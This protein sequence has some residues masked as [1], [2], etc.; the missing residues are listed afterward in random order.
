MEQDDNNKQDRLKNY[1]KFTTLAIQMG[2]LITAAA[3]GGD[4]LDENQKNE[5]PVWT[6]VLTLVAI[7]ASLFQ[8]IREV[9]KMNRDD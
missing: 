9:S 4:W 7:F 1:L 6:L 5:F 3:L 8:V 2:I